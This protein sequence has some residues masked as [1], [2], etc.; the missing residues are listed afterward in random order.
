MAEK[1]DR[2]PK[3]QL[4]TISS[5]RTRHVAHRL[6]A[7]TKRASPPTCPIPEIVPDPY[8]HREEKWK[9]PRCEVSLTGP[10]SPRRNAQPLAHENRNPKPPRRRNMRKYKAPPSQRPK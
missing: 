1:A 4:L 6:P 9:P 2:I 10:L 8:L 3:P 7:S 5:T